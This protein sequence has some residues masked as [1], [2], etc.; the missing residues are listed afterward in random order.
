MQTHKYDKSQLPHVLCTFCTLFVRWSSLSL[1][2]LGCQ[3]GSG[4]RRLLGAP[5][6]HPLA[7]ECPGDIV[8]MGHSVPLVPHVPDVAGTARNTH[9]S[10]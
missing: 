1:G 10:T 7:V 9:G 6:L 4:C 5:G 3:R 2:H 8:D